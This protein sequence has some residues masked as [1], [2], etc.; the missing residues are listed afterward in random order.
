MTTILRLL[1][2]ASICTT[3]TLPACVEPAPDDDVIDTT[4]DDDDDALPQE[5]TVE[6]YGATDGVTIVAQKA[7]EDHVFA[8]CVLEDG[9]CSLLAPAGLDLVIFAEGTNIV[10]CGIEVNLAPSAT[11]HEIEIPM[12]YGEETPHS[13][14]LFAD[15]GEFSSVVHVQTTCRAGGRVIMD[16]DIFGSYEVVGD[17]LV[18]YFQFGVSGSLL[19][20]LSRYDFS[21]GWYFIR[22]P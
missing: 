15:S 10:S 19:P 14:D 18:D 2:L 22:Q 16:T 17:Q 5:C 12:G 11:P 4:G 8:T 3:L 6:A 7:D 21:N 20:D 13:Y 1:A 9:I